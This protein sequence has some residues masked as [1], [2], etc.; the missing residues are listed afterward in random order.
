VSRIPILISL[1][2]AASLCADPA[3]SSGQARQAGDAAA[4]LPESELIVYDRSVGAARDQLTVETRLVRPEKAGAYYEITSR[5]PE[6]DLV[7]RLDPK[8]LF[9]DSIEATSRSGDAIIR[10]VTTVLASKAS[11]AADEIIV[12]S[13]EALTFSLRAFPWGEIAKAKV[14]FVGTGTRGGDFSF[15][16]K[17]AGKEK[18]VTPAGAIE[19]WKAQITMDGVFGAFVGK[20]SL[21]F[22]VEYPHYLARSESPSGMPGSPASILVLRS[23]ASPSSLR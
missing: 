7:L 18:V 4:P 1:S 19:C 22:S 5:S 2:L 9:A 11:S 14:S 6:Q 16:L 15:D 23:Y 13:A 3:R 20:T 12:S 8:T 17:V 21:W 10:R